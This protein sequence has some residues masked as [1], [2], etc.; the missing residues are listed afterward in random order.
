MMQNYTAYALIFA[1]LVQGIAVV[2]TVSGVSHQVEQNTQEISTMRKSTGEH[3]NAIARIDA[4]LE[5]IKD[6]LSVI[7]VAQKD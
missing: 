2:W 7:L 6:A 4:N 1:V 3:S 5:Y